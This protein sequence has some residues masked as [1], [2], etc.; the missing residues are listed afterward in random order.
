MSK[1]SY[2]S[3]LCMKFIVEPTFVALNLWITGPSGW[4][5]TSWMMLNSSAFS[6]VT[7]W[8]TFSAWISAHFIDARLRRWAFMI[9]CA[10]WFR[11]WF[12]NETLNKWITNITRRTRAN[13]AMIFNS[14]FSRSIAW[15][16]ICAWIYANSIL[17]ILQRTAVII[18]S[19]TSVFQWFCINY[20]KLLFM[21]FWC[22]NF[23]KTKIFIYLANT[24]FSC[25]LRKKKVKD[26]F[27]CNVCN[28]FIKLKQF[29]YTEKIAF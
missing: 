3:S 9:V 18:C 4:T 13:C 10:F 26:G 8:I 1:N 23:L 5:M 16:T 15:I 29:V 6:K 28:R 25:E 24:I 12:F 21:F 20:F 19:A 14:T 22:V 11:C 17:T 27:E 2:H 7:A